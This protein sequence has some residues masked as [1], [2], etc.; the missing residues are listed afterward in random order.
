[1]I[2]L[3]IIKKGFN[4]VVAILKDDSGLSVVEMIL[5][6]VVMIALVMIFKNQLINLVNQIF[7]KIFNESSG[8]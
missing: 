5:I 2:I 1:M 4:K 3:N 8:I 7:M 6:L